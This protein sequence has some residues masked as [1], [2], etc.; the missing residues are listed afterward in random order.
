MIINS[1]IDP[2]AETL[3]QKLADITAKTSNLTKLLRQTEHVFIAVN[4]HSAELNT[5]LANFNKNK[6]L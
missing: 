5:K 2:L 4:T 3:D 1:D 6:F